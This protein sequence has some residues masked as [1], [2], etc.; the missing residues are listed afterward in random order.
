MI[1]VLDINSD[2][3]ITWSGAVDEDGVSLVG[4]TGTWTLVTAD[5]V[6]LDSGGPRG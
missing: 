5:D 6:G 3:E 4:A 2:M 1:S